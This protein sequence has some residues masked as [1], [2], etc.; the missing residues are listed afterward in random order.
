MGV[1]GRLPD[2]GGAAGVDA[3]RSGRRCQASVDLQED[4]MN[5]V[6][7]SIVFGVAVT[8]IAL[9]EG[10]D[11]PP[12]PRASRRDHAHR[13]DLFPGGAG[14]GFRPHRLHVQGA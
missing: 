13:S 1:F 12:R 6:I 11:A 2:H 5:G 7:K 9:F 3:A 14:I 8:A 4:V 10:Y